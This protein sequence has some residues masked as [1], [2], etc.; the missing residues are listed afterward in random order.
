MMLHLS[1]LSFRTKINCGIVLID[2]DA[3]IDGLLATWERAD[4]RILNLYVHQ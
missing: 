2:D 4:I 1:A 3:D